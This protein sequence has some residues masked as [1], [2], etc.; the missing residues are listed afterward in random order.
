MVTENHILEQLIHSR[1]EIANCRKDIE[2]AFLLLKECFSKGKK[3]LLCGNGGSAADCGHIVG[4]LMKG[5]LL[6]REVPDEVTAHLVQAYGEDGQKIASSL[7]RALPAI[8]LCSNTELMTAY[9]NDVSADMLFAQQVYGYG[10]NGDVLLAISTSGNSVNV[11]NAVKIATTM[12]IKTIGLTG[13]IGGQLRNLCNV[14][15]VV[16]CKDAYKAQEMHLPIYHTL[17]AMLEFEFFGG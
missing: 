14:S 2:N 10:Q 5:F 11:L 15:I 9:I 8:S 4:E 1:K 3:L 13:G 12:G 6:K 16:P 17:C 7:Q